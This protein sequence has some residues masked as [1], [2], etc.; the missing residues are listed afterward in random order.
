[1]L[2]LQKSKTK[3]EWGKQ[4]H[5]VNWLL[6]GTTSIAEISTAPEIVNFYMCLICMNNGNQGRGS[7]PTCENGETSEQ[8]LLKLCW[9]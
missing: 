5:E 4:G 8:V 2:K 9:L 7:T 1:M 6:I 3:A